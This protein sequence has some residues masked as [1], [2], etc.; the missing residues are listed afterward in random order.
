MILREFVR[1]ALALASTFGAQPNSRRA[2]KLLPGLTDIWTNVCEMGLDF[3][4]DALSIG[5]LNAIAGD[6]FAVSP[7]WHEWP[8]HDRRDW[9]S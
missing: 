6:R 7:E 5:D 1:V 3:L 2:Q 8:F 4:D 9:R